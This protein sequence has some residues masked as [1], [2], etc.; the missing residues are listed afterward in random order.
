MKVSTEPPPKQRLQLSDFWWKQ[1]EDMPPIQIRRLWSSESR[2]DSENELPTVPST[3]K[4]QSNIKEIQDF[5][6]DNLIDLEIKDVQVIN[7]S[8][9]VISLV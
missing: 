7:K 9:Q 3:S 4:S 5:Y 8:S 6:H 1:S 2:R